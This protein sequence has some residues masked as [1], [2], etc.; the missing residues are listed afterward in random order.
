MKYSI[1]SR[2]VVGGLRF[3]VDGSRENEGSVRFGTRG[4]GGGFRARFTA[5]DGITMIVDIFFFKKKGKFGFF[6]C[7]FCF[8]SAQR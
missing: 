1:S 2:N 6:L 3:R 5:A 4:G 8:V 7:F